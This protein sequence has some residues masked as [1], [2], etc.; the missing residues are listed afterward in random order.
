MRLFND[1]EQRAPARHRPLEI[2]I[3]QH[4]IAQVFQLSL[5]DLIELHPKLKHRNRHKLGGFGTV[6]GEELSP[7]L[8]KGRKDRKQLFV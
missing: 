3:R 4:L 5:A 1:T 2:L 7:A 6:I 8:I